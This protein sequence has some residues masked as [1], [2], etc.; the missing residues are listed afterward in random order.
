MDAESVRTCSGRC[1]T[2]YPAWDTSLVGF[3]SGKGEKKKPQQ[4]LGSFPEDL[5]AGSELH[6]VIRVHFKLRCHWLYTCMKSGAEHARYRT[7]SSLALLLEQLVNSERGSLESTS[8]RKPCAT[9]G[10]SESPIK[11]TQSF[12]GGGCSWQESC[13]L[14]FKGLG[15]LP[16]DRVTM[17]CAGC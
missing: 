17:T 14:A 15:T 9:E 2:C 11:R 5:R 6:A 12:P 4:T 7:S 3:F 8:P 13:G 1:S 16:S 10:I